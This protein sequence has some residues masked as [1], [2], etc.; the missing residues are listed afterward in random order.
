M[1]S[2]YS[3][4]PESFQSARRHGPRGGQQEWQA[5]IASFFEGTGGP[6]HE[7]LEQLVEVFHLD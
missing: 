3:E 5:E 6:P 7:I 2:G 4:T 1:R